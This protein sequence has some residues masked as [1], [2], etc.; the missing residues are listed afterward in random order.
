MFVCN[1]KLNLKKII[2]TAS[3]IFLILLLF[4]FCTVFSKATFKVKDSNFSS[5]PINVNSKNYTDTL[6]IVY[7]NMQSYLNREIKITGYVYR[8]SDFCKDQFVVARKMIVE[9]GNQEFVVGFLCM[10]KDAE[11][12]KDGTWVE[13]NGNISKCNYRGKFLV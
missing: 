10:Y 7:D 4:I 1:L 13:I 5:S 8:N 11:K 3:I 6:K 9:P 12:F 2:I